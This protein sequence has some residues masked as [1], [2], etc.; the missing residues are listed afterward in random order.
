MTVLYGALILFFG[1]VVVAAY[2]FFIC[3]VLIWMYDKV[4][5]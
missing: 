5:P 3:R 2:V 1:P 4:L